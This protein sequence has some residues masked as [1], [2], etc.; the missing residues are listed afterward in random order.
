MNDPIVIE[1]PLRKNYPFQYE[2]FLLATQHDLYL[3]IEKEGTSVSAL[4]FKF[5]SFRYGG[6]NDEA[7]GSHPMTKYGLGWYG[8]YKVEHSPWIL[9]RMIAN[10]IHP[11][12]NDSMF[13]GEMHFIACFK[14]V[15]LEVVCRDFEEVQIEEAELVGILQQQIGYLE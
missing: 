4:K 15:M 1:V 3:L 9:E 5:G 13:A 6:P 11:K 10:R 7:R 14:D 8:L 12:H 2:N